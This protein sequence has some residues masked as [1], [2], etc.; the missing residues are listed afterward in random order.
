MAKA[1]Q[2]VARPDAADVIAEE[3]LTLVAARPVSSQ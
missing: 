1:A 2:A 3:L